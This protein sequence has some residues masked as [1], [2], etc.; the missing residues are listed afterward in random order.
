ML[1]LMEKAVCLV[2]CVCTLFGVF[3]LIPS[4]ANAA[5]KKSDIAF[6]WGLPNE[7]YYCVT[8]NKAPLRTNPSDSGDIITRL[9]KG[10]FVKVTGTV[11]TWK[12][13]VWLEVFYFYNNKART[14]YLYSGNAKKHSVDINGMR[15]YADNLFCDYN[16]YDN[17]GITRVQAME[18][19]NNASSKTGVKNNLL[20]ELRTRLEKSVGK[21]MDVS[22]YKTKTYY[23]YTDSNGIVRKNWDR[24]DK[25]G[26]CTWYA[27]NR[28][29]EVNGEE[30]QFK[31]AGGGNAKN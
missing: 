20:A 12:T 24:Y 8:K 21:S 1:K 13:T 23:T 18:L 4:N 9:D 2:L 14:G 6:I 15:A 26:G 30:L 28:F 10:D 19:A 11:R 31:G 7:T 5:A 16:I 3:L 17:W 22:S 25:S 29:L 27:F